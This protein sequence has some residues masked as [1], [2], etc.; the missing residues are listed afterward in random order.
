MRAM[1]KLTH[2]RGPFPLD[3][4]ERK[5]IKD[6]DFISKAKAATTYK[7]VKGAKKFGFDTTKLKEKSIGA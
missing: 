3:E 5:V 4:M 7:L 1:I 2:E 6:M